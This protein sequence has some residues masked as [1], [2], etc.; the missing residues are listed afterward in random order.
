MINKKHIIK[1]GLALSFRLS[2]Y[3]ITKIFQALGKKSTSFRTIYIDQIYVNKLQLIWS[4]RAHEILWWNSD[5]QILKLEWIFT[6]Y[7]KML[8]FCP[9][10]ANILSV[11]EGPNCFRFSCST[12]PY[13]QNI[14]SKISNR[15]YP[16]LKEVDDVLG[17]AAAWENVRPFFYIII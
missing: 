4:K 2:K 5:H 16:K 8:M 11:E 7:L 15:T 13:V 3:F 12:C 1:T 10:C 6:P 17:G 9:T 14:K